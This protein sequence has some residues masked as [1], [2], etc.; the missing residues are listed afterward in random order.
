MRFGVVFAVGG[1]G[2][3]CKGSPWG[4]MA[5]AEGVESQGPDVLTEDII[6]W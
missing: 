6:V 5:G 1:G 2:A 3:M 4:M